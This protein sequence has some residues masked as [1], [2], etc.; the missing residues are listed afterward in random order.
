MSSDSVVR[1]PDSPVGPEFETPKN[2]KKPLKPA[3]SPFE[4][5][6][7]TWDPRKKC[8]V[9]PDTRSFFGMGL[10]RRCVRCER[11]LNRETNQQFR[12]WELEQFDKWVAARSP[13]E[14]FDL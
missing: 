2:H 14:A 11:T 3:D 5:D 10:A 7:Y 13:P 1:A 6:T 9:T 4:P 12:D 8:H